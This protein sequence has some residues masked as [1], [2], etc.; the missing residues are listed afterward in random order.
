MFFVGREEMNGCVLRNEE[1]KDI[2]QKYINKS[3]IETQKSTIKQTQKVGQAF[4]RPFKL[5]K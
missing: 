2:L 1:T 4:Q 5:R 3:D